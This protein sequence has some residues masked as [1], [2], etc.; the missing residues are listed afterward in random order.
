MVTGESHYFHGR[1]YLLDVVEHDG[2]AAIRLLN[3]TTKENRKRPGADRDAAL[4]NWYRSRLR[5]EIPALLAKWER[6]AGV[7]VA[8]VRIRKIKKPWGSFSA[9]SSRVW[10]NLELV[11]KPPSCLEYVLVHEMVHL[12]ERH[13]TERF[14]E[15]MDSLMPTWR[16]HREELM[17]APLAHDDWNY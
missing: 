16:V 1:R 2:P 5:E 13:H 6:K 7:T 9:E 17:R 8:D 4:Q 15:L 11:K 3:N 10:L 14:R 12:R